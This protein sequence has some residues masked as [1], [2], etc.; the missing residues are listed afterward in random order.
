[1]NK[2]QKCAA[3]AMAVMAATVSTA[4]MAAGDASV[5]TGIQNASADG[6]EVGWLVVGVVAVFFGIRMVKSMLR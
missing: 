6:S 5:K 4:A 2:L 3:G 1:M